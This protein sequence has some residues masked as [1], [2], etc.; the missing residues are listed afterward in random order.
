MSKA[1]KHFLEAFD[2]LK[3]TSTIR[4]PKGTPVSQANVAREAGVDP[5]AL[6]KSR[7]PGVIALIQ[8]WLDAHASSQPGQGASSPVNGR[9]KARSLRDRIE[10]LTEQRDRVASLLACADARI[11]ELSME[12]ER[13][14]SELEPTNVTALPQRGSNLSTAKPSIVPK[15]R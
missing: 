9:Q 10:A 7:F 14:R 1:E 6:R 12:C 2:R 15:G 5:S 13:L 11:V 8:Q 4:L 3:N